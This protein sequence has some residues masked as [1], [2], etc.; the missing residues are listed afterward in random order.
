M[1]RVIFLKDAILTNKNKAY[2]T[3]REEDVPFNLG[4]ELYRSEVT[5]V[6]NPYENDDLYNDIER[7]EKSWEEFLRWKR[8]GEYE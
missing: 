3:G 5:D 6:L 1:L 7:Y 4:V 2:R 8:K